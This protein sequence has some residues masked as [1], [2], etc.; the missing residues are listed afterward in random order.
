MSCA[1][2]QHSKQQVEISFFARD[3][4]F[5]FSL[6]S[7]FHWDTAF[8]RFFFVCLFRSVEWGLLHSSDSNDQNSA[9]VVQLRI[10]R[11]KKTLERRNN[12]PFE[13][14]RVHFQHFSS[15]HIEKQHM[16]CNINFEIRE[17]VYT[18]WFYYNQSNISLAIL[19]L[20]CLLK[21][22]VVMTREILQFYN[23]P[24]WES[25]HYA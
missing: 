16:V 13:S 4:I 12:I 18:L 19:S 24:L 2:L 25:F 22:G 14:I 23:I 17:F 9:N 11:C 1:T 3:T 15:K 21:N 20:W 6:L 8:L 10:Y 5:T 7:N